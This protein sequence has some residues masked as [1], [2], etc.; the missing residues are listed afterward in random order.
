MSRIGGTET[1]D[2]RTIGESDNPEEYLISCIEKSKGKRPKGK[3]MKKIANKEAK[4]EDDD[5]EEK[6]EI[7]DEITK[8][9]KINEETVVEGNEGSKVRIS[10]I[11]IRILDVA[12][13]L[14]FNLNWEIRHGASLIIRAA[15]RKAHMFYYFSHYDTLRSFASK[16]FVVSLKSQIEKEKESGIKGILEDSIIRSLLIL[17]LDRFS[18]FIGDKSN[19]IVRDISSQAVAD[20]LN[21]LKS[22]EITIKMIKYFK[23]LLA[24][25][26]KQGWEVSCAHEAQTRRY[27]PD[28]QADRQESEAD[29]CLLQRVLRRDHGASR[30]A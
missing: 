11:L 19:I 7:N 6:D 5:E 15:A 25:D 28:V 29:A 14:L 2:V 1:F 12:R 27:L 4:D 22:Q 26:I 9:L 30:R 16:E 17:A 3:T 20:S 24:R 10:T 8:K 13:I 18:D 21:Y 23:E